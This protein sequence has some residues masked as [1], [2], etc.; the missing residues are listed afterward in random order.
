MIEIPDEVSNW[1]RQTFRDSNEAATAKLSRNP[2]AKEEWLDLS[3]IDRLQMAATP[4][5]FRDT[6]WTA[7]IDVHFLGAVPMFRTWEVADIGLLVAFRSSG[8][9]IR[10]KVALLQSKRLFTRTQRPETDEELERRYMTGFSTVLHDD[11]GFAEL[12]RGRVFRFSKASRYKSLKNGSRQ[13]TT[14]EQYETEKQVPVY[15]LFY[16]PAT[17]PYERVVPIEAGTPFDT[18]PNV[19]CR[20][21]PA[22]DVRRI[23]SEHVSATGTLSYQKLAKHLPAHFNAAQHR[24]GWTLEFFVV[25]LLLQCKVGRVYDGPVDPALFNVFY[26]RTGP[27]AA[28]VS[29]TIDAPAGFDWTV[30]PDN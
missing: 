21:A 19:G 22:V 27:I 16:N 29:I 15:Y 12:A 5:T 26:R 24:G 8:K 2:S 13:I 6:G 14:I 9:L 28:A 18:T 4:Y 10:T 7:M 3:I 23:M 11:N 20:I 30:A 25:D 1:L 17:L